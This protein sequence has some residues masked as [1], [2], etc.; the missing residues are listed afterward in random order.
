MPPAQAEASSHGHT[1]VGQSLVVT[2]KGVM[3]VLQITLTMH[4]DG[5]AGYLVFVDGL[6][7]A[8]LPGTGPNAMNATTAN[9][10]LLLDG[11]RPIFLEVHAG[12]SLCAAATLLLTASTTLTEG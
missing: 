4:A 10:E 2:S 1:W 8:S 12:C 9:P 6:L 3:R 7:A 5:S 11:G